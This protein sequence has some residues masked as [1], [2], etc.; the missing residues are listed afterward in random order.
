MTIVPKPRTLLVAALISIRPQHWI[1]NVFVLA[2]LVF[3]RRFTD[4]SALFSSLAAFGLFCAAASSVYLLND[5][6]DRDADRLHPQ[7]RKR[8]LA[9]GEISPVIA[10]ALA[11]FLA[12]LALI[13]ASFLGSRFA[14]VLAGYL[15]MNVAYLFYLKKVVI[16]DVMTLAAGFLLR[17]LAGSVVIDVDLSNWLILCTGLIALF[18]GFIKR[19]QELLA[20]ESSGPSGR[21]TLRRYSKQFLDQVI[22]VVTAATLV[23]Y[24]LYVFSPEV[25]KNLRTP[26]MGLTLPFVMYGI[27]RYL[28]L[29]HARGAGESPVRL[30]FE[31]RPLLMTILLWCMA[32]LLLLALS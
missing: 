16:L 4:L 13:A 2:P 8:P 30:I 23:A 22:T 11:L 5:L 14:A 29:V 7:K 26:Y 28:H 32:V 25:A 21:S 19:R 20:M 24:S 17:T 3:S 27:L 6:F 1:K 10:V 9:A 18:L 12:G 31:D 15:A